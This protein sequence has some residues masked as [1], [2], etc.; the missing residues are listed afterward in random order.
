MTRIS[1]IWLFTFGAFAG[2]AQTLTC[3]F[4]FSGSGSLGT[5]T[6]TNAAITITTVGN[7]ANLGSH[8]SSA[9]GTSGYTTINN[10]SASILISGVEGT[11]QFT[12]PTQTAVQVNPSNAAPGTWVSETFYFVVLSQQLMGGSEASTTNQWKMLGPVG[13]ITSSGALWGW[14]TTPILTSGGTV[15]LYDATTPV[16]FQATLSGTPPAL[17]ITRS[18]VLSHIAAGGGW[19]TKITLINPSS[20]DL[21]VTVALHSD[22]GSALTRTVGVIQQG[23]SHNIHRFLH[24]CDD[25]PQCHVDSQ[26]RWWRNHGCRM[27]R[28]S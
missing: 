27:G 15:D 20:K 16:T 10:T 28:C 11:F 9:P 12:A 25:W 24:Q 4:Q 6:F 19:N 22:D 5:H 2:M 7:T 23:S 3:T 17:T 1:L 18:G 13:P 8:G 26:Y 14:N 21:P